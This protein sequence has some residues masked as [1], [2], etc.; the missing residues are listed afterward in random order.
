MPVWCAQ[1]DERA[2]ERGAD[3]ARRSRPSATDSSENHA[4]DARRAPCRARAACRTRASARRSPSASCSRRRPPRRRS[5]STSTK[6]QATSHELDEAR[7]S[8]ARASRQSSTSAPAELG[9]RRELAPRAAGGPSR[10]PPVDHDLVRLVGHREQRLRLAS[11]MTHGLP[12][13][14]VDRGVDERRDREEIVGE[15]AV[16]AL[17]DERDLVARAHAHL[18]GEQPPHEHALPGRAARARRRAAASGRDSGARSTPSTRTANP[19]SP[20]AAS[21]GA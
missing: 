4:D 10:V 20:S 12:V 11:A 8:P 7:P 19:S 3:A 6:I 1:R 15:R 16:H 14:E 2:A 17:S 18:L 9:Q 5:T 13:H 21:A